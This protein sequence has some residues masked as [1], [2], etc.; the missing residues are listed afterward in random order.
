MSIARTSE[1]VDIDK[2][3]SSC[4][5]LQRLGYKL[6]GF[7]SVKGSQKMEMVYCDLYPN[8]N[9]RSYF[10]FIGIWL[11]IFFY[12]TDKQKWIG[13]V[14]V[15]SSPVH[16]HV[17]RNSSFYSIYTPIPFDFA[18]VNEGNAMDLTTGKFI[19]KRPGIYFFSFKGSIHSSM[20]NQLFQ[21][22]LNLNGVAIGESRHL[23]GAGQHPWTIQST[24]YMNSDDQVWVQV[25][26]P[27]EKVGSPW[28][29]QRLWPPRVEFGSYITHFICSVLE[30]DI[31]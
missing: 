31:H 11:S 15:K 28:R 18:L 1:I 4:A 17:Q 13:Y 5:D 12:S 9:G 23:P 8:Q 19:A 27:G 30:E 7:F 26:M 6:S 14:D 21:I 16:F 10:H 20:I 25:E 3:P 22:L 2:M 29:N 24:L